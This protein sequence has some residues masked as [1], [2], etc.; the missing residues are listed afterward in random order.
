MINQRNLKNRIS[1]DGI[2]QIIS[3][4]SRSQLKNKK[5]CIT[6]FY[7]LLEK[8]LIK[9]KKRKKSKIPRSYHRKRLELKR[10]QS[11]KKQNRRKFF[12]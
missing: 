5:T 8:A 2:L 1:N 10:R 4:A 12:D 7:E 11:E 6:K 3:Q 9:P